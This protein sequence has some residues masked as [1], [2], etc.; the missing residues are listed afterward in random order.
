M[1]ASLC[2]Y[3]LFAIILHA[4]AETPPVLPH[5]VAWL[6]NDREVLRPNKKPINEFGIQ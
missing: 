2:D 3:L 5:C 1:L 4:D 6:R